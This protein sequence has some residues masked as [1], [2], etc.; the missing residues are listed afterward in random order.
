MVFVCGSIHLYMEVQDTHCHLLISPSLELTSLPEEFQKESVDVRHIVVDSFGIGEARSLLSLSSQTAWGENDHT[1]VIATS[2]ITLEAQNALLKLFEDP[3]SRTVFYLV[4][5]QES[6]LIPTLRSRF[7]SAEVSTNN[8]E[9]DSAS[10]DDFIKMSLGERMDYIA[11]KNKKDPKSLEELVVSL[12]SEKD[13][14]SPKARKALLLVDKY[15]YNQGA[16]RKML[17]EELA[18]SL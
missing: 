2:K 11:E 16:S 4:I 7:V 3:P 9:D 17:L 10:A 8:T 5:P 6:L 1:F 13:K 14:L 12:G 15:V 18:L